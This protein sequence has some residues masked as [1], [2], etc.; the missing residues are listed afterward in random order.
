MTELA[1]KVIR[2]PRAEPELDLEDENCEAD[3][4]RGHDP[5]ACHHANMDVEE[6]E[7]D[8]EPVML[9]GA[10]GDQATNMDLDLDHINDNLQ[11]IID[12]NVSL[13]VQFGDGSSCR[14]S[15]VSSLSFQNIV[16]DDNDTPPEVMRS[17]R[18]SEDS[19]DSYQND[20]TEADAQAFSGQLEKFHRQKRRANDRSNTSS[21]AGA[22]VDDMADTDE[23]MGEHHTGTMKRRSKVMDAEPESDQQG[24]NDDAAMSPRRHHQGGDDKSRCQRERHV[25]DEEAGNSQHENQHTAASQRCHSLINTADQQSTTTATTKTAAAANKASTTSNA[26]RNNTSSSAEA[27]SASSS[28]GNSSTQP[29]N[30]NST[31][32]KDTTSNTTTGEGK[33]SQ[34]SH[35]NASCE[36]AHN[37]TER[38]A[39]DQE[40]DNH[41]D[42]LPPSTSSLSSSS[43]S[44][45]VTATDAAVTTA[46]TTHHQSDNSNS[47]SSSSGGGQTMS[48]ARNSLEVRNNIPVYRQVKDYHHDT[49]TRPHHHP[50]SHHHPH[51]TAMPRIKKI[52]P[53]LARRL[54]S[55]SRSDERD[56]SSS[57]KETD[58][59]LDYT[60]KSGHAEMRSRL[61]NGIVPQP[62]PMHHEPWEDDSGGGSGGSSGLGTISEQES[63]EKACD[64]ENE[65][66]YVKWTRVQEGDSYVGMRLA[67][68]SSNDSLSYNNRQRFRHSGTPSDD[69]HYLG[70]SRENSPEKILQPRISEHMHRNVNEDTLT[71]IPLNGN[72]IGSGEEQKNFSLSPEATECDSAEVESVL[73]DEGKSS[74]SGMPVVEDGLSSSQCSD[75]DEAFATHDPRRPAEILKRRYRNEMEQQGITTNGF[76]LCR[77]PHSQEKES[78]NMSQ[79]SPLS[80]PSSMDH[81]QNTADRDALSLAI[82]DIKTAIKRSKSATLKSPYQ[83][84]SASTEEP[85]WI[86]R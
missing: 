37:Q 65:Y 58:P 61:D 17:R 34:D 59:Q 15:D 8:N 64:I 14:A 13:E 42:S 67:Y 7:E 63:R 20:F 45:P 70:S 79:S 57:E 16:F 75:I 55:D 77:G 47:S 40:N 81:C 69:G 6:E 73:S 27:T 1:G 62:H 2:A 85:I 46:T 72:D 24:D 43:S 74:T 4:R 52:S 86:M 51:H 71:E 68:A 30:A 35:N 25:S 9:A 50:S 5:N 28:S 84:N 23:P 53:G 26:A 3:Q 11:D 83:E 38:S 54:S 33:A 76:E 60:V 49:D 78:E 80:S 31:N 22:N 36:R 12:D 10:G 32:S 48:E 39:V 56:T 29:A 21:P 41:T 18:D 19:S 66:D 82:Q 44:S